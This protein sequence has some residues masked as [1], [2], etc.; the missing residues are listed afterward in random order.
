M[1]TSI[2]ISLVISEVFLMVFI[3]DFY[4]SANCLE[5]YIAFY[6]KEEFFLIYLSQ[7]VLMESYLFP[8]GYNHLPSL[9]CPRSTS[10]GPFMQAPV[11]Y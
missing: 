8:M 2:C 11:C 10:E 9:N 1:I 7:S 6:S 5:K 3:Q 4:V